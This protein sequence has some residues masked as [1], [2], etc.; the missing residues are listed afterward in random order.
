[1]TA[2]IENTA[3]FPTLEPADIATIE[4]LG[5]RRAVGIGD[6]LYRSG[7]DSYDFYVVVSARS[8]S[9]W[10]ATTPALSAL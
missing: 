3:A 8:T 2:A 7:D 1:M 9:S 4:H 6:Y 10:T 5:T